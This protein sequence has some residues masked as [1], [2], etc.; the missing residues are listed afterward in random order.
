MTVQ[1]ADQLTYI[2]NKKES[3]LQHFFSPGLFMTYMINENN[4]IRFTTA[5][6]SGDLGL[7]YRSLTEQRIDK[8]QISRGKGI[9]ILFDGFDLFFKYA[10]F[11]SYLSY[12]V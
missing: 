8:Y 5:L 1:W 9:E 12:F 3:S 6:E 4:S 2:D 10:C 11:Q 7:Q